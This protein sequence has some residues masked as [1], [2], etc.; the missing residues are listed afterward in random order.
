MLMK[1]VKLIALDLDGTIVREDQSISEE[2]RMAIGRAQNAG[3]AVVIA[4]G[5]IFPTAAAWPR[6]LHTN[7]PVICCN[8]ADIRQGGISIFERPIAQEQLRAAYHAME[9]Y[10]A[11]L[12][13]F[14]GDHVYCTKQ[15]YNETMFKKWGFY[16]AISNLVVY[17]ADLDE[18]LL[19]VRGNAAKF[20]VRTLDESQHDA[21]LSEAR[22][23]PYFDIMK[24]EAMNFELVQK[25]VSKGAG[26]VAIA[27]ML[28]VDM[29]DTIAIGDSTNDLEM[30][31]DAG[32]GIA[33]GNAMPE[34]LEAADDVTAPIWQNGVARA[35]NKYVFGEDSKSIPAV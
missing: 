22:S 18:I 10:R 1:T 26:L 27:Q 21:I 16:D 12:Y 34:I 2:D 9:K 8:G 20:L 5:R 28:G 7:A 33:M 15:D 13:A 14:C 35:I 11:L 6:R 31:R 30:I 19:K 25:G 24:G 32:V 3:A 4:T 29:Q 23:L 17:C